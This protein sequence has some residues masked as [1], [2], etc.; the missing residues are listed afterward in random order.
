MLYNLEW[1]PNKLKF[2]CS[3]HFHRQLWH[4]NIPWRKQTSDF[5]IWTSALRFHI[6][7]QNNYIA[8]GDRG[9]PSRRRYSLNKDRMKIKEQK[10]K[11]THPVNSFH[12]WPFLLIPVFTHKPL[13]ITTHHWSLHQQQHQIK[14]TTNPHNIDLKHYGFFT[15]FI[16]AF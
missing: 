2:T 9:N 14:S 16:F 11:A 5:I 6:S 7:L 12:I 3:W 15:N 13:Y 4:K 10:V 8:I 1:L